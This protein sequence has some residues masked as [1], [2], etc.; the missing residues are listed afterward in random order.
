MCGFPNDLARKDSGNNLV[1][2]VPSQSPGHRSPPEVHSNQQP[3]K[4]SRL[5]IPYKHVNNVIKIRKPRLIGIDNEIEMP[6]K[7]KE[8]NLR[9]REVHTFGLSPSGI[10]ILMVSITNS[11]L[12]GTI[13]GEEGLVH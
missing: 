10:R 6:F 1:A 9:A 7:F 2:H 5:N 11:T 8:I 4:I 3:T 13:K 12:K